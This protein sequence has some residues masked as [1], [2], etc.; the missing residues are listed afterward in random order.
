MADAN[1]LA[2][3]RRLC[4]YPATPRL[5]VEAA[6]EEKEEEEE[7]EGKRKGRAN[8]SPRS[9]PKSTIDFVA[10]K[11]SKASLSK[12]WRKYTPYPLTATRLTIGPNIRHRLEAELL[13]LSLS[14][15]PPSTSRRRQLLAL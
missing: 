3:D 14:L 11:I 12:H 6:A 9:S 7:E 1:K 5:A 13:A 10:K 8:H 15:P 4:F 2:K